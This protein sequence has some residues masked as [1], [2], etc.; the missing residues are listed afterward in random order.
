NV[1]LAADGIPRLGDF[2]TSGGFAVGDQ[3]LDEDDPAGL[4][5]WT[6]ERIHEP[7]GE[8]HPSIDVYG[9]G[10]ILYELLTG[11]PPFAARTA[12]EMLEQITSQE[13]ASPAALN[14][15]VTPPLEACCLRCLH[16]SPWQRYHRVYD[17]VMRLR[18]LQKNPDGQPAPANQRPR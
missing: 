10:V 8:L 5:Y 11:R 14:R 16:K 3:P 2:H 4:V 15:F 12:H 6:P 17:L 9:L 7:R 1:L 18:Y 13:P